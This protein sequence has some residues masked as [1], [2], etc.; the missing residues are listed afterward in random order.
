MWLPALVLF[1]VSVS[2]LPT[3]DKTTK[4]FNKLPLC[5]ARAN[6]TVLC[7]PYVEG[8]CCKDGKHCC[9]KESQCHPDRGICIPLN[10]LG[11][12]LVKTH[13]SFVPLLKQNITESPKSEMCPSKK[14]MCPSKS[15]CCPGPYIGYDCCPVPNGICCGNFQHC[16]PFNTTC[17]TK[18]ARCIDS[19]G[20]T[21]PWYHKLKALPTEKPR[22]NKPQMTLR[23]V[24][25]YGNSTC[26]H[27]K[28]VRCTGNRTCCAVG[29]YG[30]Y[31]CC[32]SLNA[33][34]CLGGNYCC[35]EGTSCDLYTQTCLRVTT[36]S[37]KRI[38]PISLNLI[39][40]TA[41]LKTDIALLTSAMKNASLTV[42]CPGGKYSCPNYMT[43]CQSNIKGK[44][45]CCPF[46]DATCCSDSW[47]CCPSGSKCDLEH[48]RC[49]RGGLFMPLFTKTKAFNVGAQQALPNE[50][51]P[52]KSQC[53]EGD[54]CC[55]LPSSMYGCC[56]LQEAVCCDD[57]IHCCPHGT[58]CD[59]QA[60][61]CNPGNSITLV[62][63]FGLKMKSGKEP[64]IKKPPVSSVC[65][66]GLFECPHKSTCCLSSNKSWGCCPY[67][68]AIC[69]NDFKH[70]C[71]E[72]YKCDMQLGRCFNG[73]VTI[74]F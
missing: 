63:F 61:G 52:D 9:P 49:T 3:F 58:V 14:Q 44:Y 13:L 34:C 56:P 8:T 2:A 68:N 28:T 46:P 64:S 19:S 51:C 31:G 38:A 1:F 20:Q 15:S 54:T 65:P 73:N 43:C 59:L 48:N 10:K 17:D 21:V 45:G 35:P 42:I 72:G 39:S 25:G 69:C 5:A 33:V 16:C 47:H 55:K 12:P 74:N 26:P 66:G 57:H 22:H 24:Q 50:E 60:G 11:I 62:P 6:D 30:K 53:P 18:H 29:E 27:S 36:K 71:P 32:D 40:A 67:D 70:C 7:C 23:K 41:A 37:G 4:C